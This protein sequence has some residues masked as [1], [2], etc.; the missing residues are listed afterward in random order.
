MTNVR[1]GM[2]CSFFELIRGSLVAFFN[3]KPPSFPTVPEEELKICQYLAFGH[4]ILRER[5][6]A[7]FPVSLSLAD[8]L[9]SRGGGTCE[10]RSIVVVVG[11]RRRRRFV[12]GDSLLANHFVPFEGEGWRRLLTPQHQHHQ[13]QQEQYRVLVRQPWVPLTHPII[14][15]MF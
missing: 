6:K 12:V 14:M 11:G 3:R 5:T 4:F 10:D 2:I 9:P 8:R 7:R 1:W 13:H 15:L